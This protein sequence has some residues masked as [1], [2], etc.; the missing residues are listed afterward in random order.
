M[1][2]FFVQ[3]YKDTKTKDNVSVNHKKYGP[4]L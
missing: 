4:K 2:T 3:K 1:G